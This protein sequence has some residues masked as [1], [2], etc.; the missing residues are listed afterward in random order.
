MKN[1]YIV[2]DNKDKSITYLEYD[3]LSGYDI[4]PKNVKIKNAIDVNKMVI[5]NP[6]MISKMVT[7]KVN[8]KFERLLKF[9]NVVFDEEDPSGE[10]YR[11]ALTEITKLSLEYFIK[12]KNYMVKEQLELLEKKLN[13]LERE[14][15]IRLLYLEQVNSYNY[16]DNLAKDGKSR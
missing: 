3:K 5:I 9:V 16:E 11:Q 13:I 2:K 14:L 7:K 4:T 6:G 10:G 8:L 15:K 12:Y 1:Y